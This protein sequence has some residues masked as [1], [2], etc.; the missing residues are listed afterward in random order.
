MKNTT[1][2][3]LTR[4]YTNF[5]NGVSLLYEYVYCDITQLGDLVVL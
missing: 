1:P 2:L 3:Q 5:S 4:Q